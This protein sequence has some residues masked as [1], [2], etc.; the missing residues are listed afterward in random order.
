MVAYWLSIVC[1]AFAEAASI[2]SESP[3]Q[4]KWNHPLQPNKIYLKRLIFEAMQAGVF[5]CLKG[6]NHRL[7]DFNVEE[8]NNW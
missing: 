6:K 4:I 1:K 2:C 3:A 8:L 5:V 7:Q